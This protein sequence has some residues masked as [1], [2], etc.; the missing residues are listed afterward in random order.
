MGGLYVSV[1]FQE[2]EAGFRVQNPSTGRAI[3]TS[4]LLRN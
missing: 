2:A 4:G 3:P 1:V